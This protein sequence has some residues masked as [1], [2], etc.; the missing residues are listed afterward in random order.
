MTGRPS[1]SEQLRPISERLFPKRARI[2]PVTQ[3]T[4]DVVAKNDQSDVLAEARTQVLRWMRNR[5]GSLPA[6]AWKHEDFEVNES[7]TQAAA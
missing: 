6:P 3:I 5:A 7:G 1:F 4:A 2:V